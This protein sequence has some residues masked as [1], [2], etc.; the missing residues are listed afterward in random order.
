MKRPTP[1]QV[2]AKINEEFSG[3]TPEPIWELVPDEEANQGW[4]STLSDTA[5]TFRCVNRDEV[6]ENFVDWVAYGFKRDLA[7]GNLLSPEEVICY[8]S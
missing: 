1:E 2:L 5:V 8:L 7:T 6:G 3:V 4:S